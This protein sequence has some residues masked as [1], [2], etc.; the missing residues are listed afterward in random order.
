MSKLSSG[1]RTAEGGVRS[2]TVLPTILTS[3]EQPEINIAEHYNY[4]KNHMK[5]VID[6]KQD[7][8]PFVNVDLSGYSVMGLLDSGATCTILGRESEQL[9]KNL[10]LE[11]SKVHITVSTAD[12]TAHTVKGSVNIPYFF[13]GKTNVIPTLVVPS[14]SKRLILGC[15]F[16]K[17]F[18]L[19]ITVLKEINTV[20]SVFE[21][22]PENKYSDAHILNSEQSKQLESVKLLF[23]PAKDGFLSGTKIIRHHIDTGDSKPIRT[24]AHVWSPYLQKEINTEIQ[25]MLDLGVIQPSKSS[26]A[27]PLVPVRKS[28]GKLRLCLDSRKL[29]E[30]TRRDNYPIPHMGRITKRLGKSEYFSAIDMSDAFWQVELDDESREKRHLSF[31]G[32]GFSNMFGCHSVWSTVQ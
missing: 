15:D 1:K 28:N 22:E 10:G 14:I 3:K 9:I 7:N 5:L 16:W 17:A 23:I 8:R 12:G 18:D 4:F 32:E 21:S 26:W 19:C 29:N 2:Q 20:E 30:V 24:S 6:L 31:M 11:L 13:N 25:R 27:F